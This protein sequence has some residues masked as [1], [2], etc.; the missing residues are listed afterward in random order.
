MTAALLLLVNQFQAAYENEQVLKVYEL[1]M[2]V[3]E[4]FLMYRL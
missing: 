4:S 2:A 3:W 1:K